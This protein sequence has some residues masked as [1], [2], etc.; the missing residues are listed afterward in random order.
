MRAVVTGG[1]G[2]IGSHVV[3]A[4]LARG[5]EVH[6]LDDLSKGKPDRV[7]ARRRSMSPT[8]ATPTRP[9]TRRSPRLVFHLAAQADVRVSVERPGLRRRRERPRHR[10]HPRGGAPARCAGHLLLD[11]RRDLRRV[12]RPGA[13]DGRAAAARAL[14]HVEALRRGVPGDVEPP[15]RDAA[16]SRCASA[17]STGR[18]RSRTARRASSRSSWASCRTAAPRR[19][20]ATAARRATT[21]TSATSSRAMLA[22]MRAHEGGVYNVGTGHGDVRARA[23]RGDPAGGRDRARARIAP[24]RLGELQRSVL[25]PSTRGRELGWRPETALADGLATTWRWVA[26]APVEGAAHHGANLFG[27]CSTP[28]ASRPPSP[29]RTATSSPASSQLVELS[30]SIA[31][32]ASLASRRPE[33]RDSRRTSATVHASKPVAARRSRRLP[34][35]APPA[36]ARARSRPQRQRRLGAAAGAE[37]RLELRGLSGRRRRD[38]CAAA[39]LRAVDGDVRARLGE[40]GAPAR[41]E[42]RRPHRLAGRRAPRRAAQGVEARAR[43]SAG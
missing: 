9:S 34:R 42:T 27:P 7:D 3:E 41:A 14:R 2:F 11:G 12:R 26:A 13:G 20:S 39:R 35:P 22:A 43:S 38:E 37:Q 10:P 8:S 31:D 1:A 28:N 40:G 33:P 5:D 32:R 25:D 17:T 36:R 6:V 18:A 4:L 16:T 15:L 19:S 21:S 23:L 24:A 29:W 30:R